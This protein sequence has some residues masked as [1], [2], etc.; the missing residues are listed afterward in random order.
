[1]S[2]LSPL[3]ETFDI[4]KA[5]MPHLKFSWVI[6]SLRLPAENCKKEMQFPPHLGLDAKILQI[7]LQLLVFA[8]PLYKPQFIDQAYSNP[9][10]K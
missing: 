3:V 5:G 7:I 8:D 9:G 4:L 2:D 1:M 6:K 10:Q